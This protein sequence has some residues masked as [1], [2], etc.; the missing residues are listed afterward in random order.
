MKLFFAAFIGS[1]IPSILFAQD[2]TQNR[3]A[4]QGNLIA[5]NSRINFPLR[6]NEIDLFSIYLGSGKNY[7]REESISAIAAKGD[8]VISPL[9]TLLFME[10]FTGLNLKTPE[11]GESIEVFA[12][13]MVMA[14][15]SLEQIGSE[16]AFIV[17]TEVALTHK[18]PYVRSFALRAL[19][20]SL[21][22]RVMKVKVSPKADV[23]DAFIQS[24]DD[25]T[26]IGEHQKT[27][28]QIADDGLTNWLGFTFDDPQFDQAKGKLIKDKTFKG[29]I[30][31]AKNW[32]INNAPQISWN[33][34]VGHFEV[35]K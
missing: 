30:D 28:K 25:S 33:K 17:I 4:S 11:N 26:F 23:I 3:N 6:P 31:F 21:H 1:I 10:K 22:E 32:R 9:E 27:I 24:C 13:Q 14:L 19:A 5:S 15:T 20:G 12:P 8:T 7:T 18:S 16:K 29:T 35:K 2:T 34:D